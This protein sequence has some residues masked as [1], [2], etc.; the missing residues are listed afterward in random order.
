M[1][2]DDE[3]IISITQS[4]FCTFS[5]SLCSTVFIPSSTPPL[6]PPLRLKT[7]AIC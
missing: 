7:T 2:C 4:F 6:V 3:D 5:P 1:S